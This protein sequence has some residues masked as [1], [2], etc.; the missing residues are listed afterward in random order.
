[1][2]A[3]YEENPQRARS[4][5]SITPL[6]PPA[7]IAGRQRELTLVLN[8]YEAAKGGHA[9]V[10]LLVGEPRI[11]KTRLL[12]EV[13]LGTAQDAA[14]VLRGGSAEAKRLPPLLRV[15]EALG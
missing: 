7:P 10:V 15:F 9:H 14:I 13:A 2:T 4:E 6:S 3:R 5:P 11:G 8:H 12:D 1:M